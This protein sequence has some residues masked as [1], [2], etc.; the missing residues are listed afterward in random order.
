[1]PMRNTALIIL[2]GWG[3]GLQDENDATHIAQTPTVDRLLAGQ[4]ARLITHGEDVGLPAGQMGNS[5][6]GHMN[7]G[8]GRVV[9]Q[10]L[11]RIDRAIASGDFAKEQP[12]QAAMSRAAAKGRLHLMG[13]V[14]KGGVHSQQAHLHALIDVAQETGIEEVFVHVFT[15]GRDTAPRR[16]AAYIEELEGHICGTTAIIATVSG[17]YY[18]MDRDERWGRVAKAYDVLVGRQAPCFAS[19]AQGIQSAYESG[20]GD[21]FIEPFSIEGVNGEIRQGDTV[22]CFNF[23]TDR[24]REITRALTQE[25]FAEQG[26]EPL[27]LDYVTMTQYDERF[28]GVRVI[29]EKPDLNDTLGEVVSAAGGRQIRIAE[30]EKYP[31]VTFFFN[32]GREAEFHGEQRKVIPSPGVAT[33]DLQPEMSAEGVA[34]AGIDAIRSDQPPHF[35]CLNFANP[36]MVG[37]SGV[38]DA[39]VR[40]VETA[41]AQLARV[42]EVAESNDYS[43]VVIADHGNAEL[44]RNPDGS[45]HT[46]HTTN[47]VPIIVVDPRKP[48]VKDGRLADIAPTVLALMGLEQPEAMTGTVLVEF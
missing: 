42:L 30:T 32:G 18:A 3:F 14:S 43:V 12:L 4:H 19:A 33:Y 6:V 36:D 13:L 39:V 25:R 45:P 34:Q 16:A 48:A 37:H 2:D 28:K 27:E 41:D 17:R 10:D 38:F 20:V 5:E 29:Y 11:L 9:Y 22:I 24:C 7:I 23:R 35:L 47:L 15:D 44:A 1:M 26:M 21:E 31:H 46:A 40:A 8:A